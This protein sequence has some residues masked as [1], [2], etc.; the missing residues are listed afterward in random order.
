LVSWDEVFF[1]RHFHYYP[2]SWGFCV[3]GM[4]H[5]LDPVCLVGRSAMRC[6]Q[7]FAIQVCLVF[8]G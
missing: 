5:C 6:R 2:K 7:L 8:F 1:I 3:A 4:R